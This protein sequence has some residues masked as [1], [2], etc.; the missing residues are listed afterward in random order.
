LNGAGKEKLCGTQRDFHLRFLWE[1]LFFEQY[2][3]KNIR[4]FIVK[5]YLGY[6]FTTNY[7]PETMLAVR[8]Y[9]ASLL[10]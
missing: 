6:C 7:L 5:R 9:P 1:N 4:I 3:M 8:C 10:H 2:P